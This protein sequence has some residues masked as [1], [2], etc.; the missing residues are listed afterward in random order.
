MGAG[1]RSAIPALKKLEESDPQLRP[2]IQKALSQ[3]KRA[4]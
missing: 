1:A 2:L 3:I 4:Q